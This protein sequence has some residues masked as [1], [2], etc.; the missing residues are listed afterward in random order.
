MR[1]I[2]IGTSQENE[3]SLRK[4]SLVVTARLRA[5]EGTLTINSCD[6]LRRSVG[7][8]ECELHAS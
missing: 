3:I 4:W 5:L 7:P 2:K 8:K 1:D 6:L